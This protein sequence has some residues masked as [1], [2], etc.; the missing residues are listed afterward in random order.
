MTTFFSVIFCVILAFEACVI[1]LMLLTIFT[2]VGSSLLPL[3]LGNVKNMTKPS[4][5]KQWVITT[6]CVV[7]IW[8]LSGLSVGWLFV[9]LGFDLISVPATLWFMK[10]SKYNPVASEMLAR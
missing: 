2:P 8:R 6:T 4:L 1:V 5:L 10:L 9:S 3:F 7:V